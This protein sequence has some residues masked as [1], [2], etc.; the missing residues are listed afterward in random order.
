MDDHKIIETAQSPKSLILSVFG[1][2][3]LTLDWDLDSG[4][5]IK[6]IKPLGDYSL[7]RQIHFR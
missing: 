3:P 6:T 4:F 2:R 7:S 5:S 1:S